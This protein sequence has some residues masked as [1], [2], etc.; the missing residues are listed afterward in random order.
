MI[1]NKTFYGVKLLK[2]GQKKTPLKEKSPGETSRGPSK[3]IVKLPLVKN[4]SILECKNYQLG[5][6]IGEGAFAKVYVAKRTID[7]LKC[8]IKLI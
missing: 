4:S 2:G 7:G 5:D 8:V 3:S 1:T 6:P